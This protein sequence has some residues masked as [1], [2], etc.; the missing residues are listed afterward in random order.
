MPNSYRNSLS[1]FFKGRRS[2]QYTSHYGTFTRNFQDK[3][4]LKFHT[5][6]IPCFTSLQFATVVGT[7]LSIYC[8]CTLVTSFREVS[9]NAEPGNCTAR[10]ADSTFRPGRIAF[11]TYLVECVSIQNNQKFWPPTFLAPV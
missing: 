10:Q 6:N 4:S 2:L 11:S 5:R 3:K 9:S 8:Y 7:H 1:L